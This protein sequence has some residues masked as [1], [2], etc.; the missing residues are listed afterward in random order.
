MMDSIQIRYSPDETENV[1][2]STIYCVGLNYAEHA[3]EMKSERPQEP[4]I[5]IKPASALVTGNRDVEYPAQTQELHHEVEV[6]VALA[7]DARHLTLEQAREMVLAYGIGLDLTL[8]DRQSEA[9][10][11]GRPWAVA[12]GFAQS[13][14]V[15]DFVPADQVTSPQELDFSLMVNGELRQQGNTSQLLFAIPEL[16]AYLSSVFQLRRGDLIFTGT[17][18]GVGPLQRGDHV[19]ARLEGLAAL[20]F[21]VV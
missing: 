7:Q 6:V 8:R 11:K 18:A 19:E 13:A 5:F 2:I 16:I 12:K 9:K 14:P 3:V 1:G 21:E 20:S 10:A 15:S 17:P 4:V